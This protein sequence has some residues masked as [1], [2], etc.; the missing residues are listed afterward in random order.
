MHFDVYRAIVIPLEKKLY[1]TKCSDFRTIILLGHA[2]KVLI[3]I[4]TKRI[5]AKAEG[6]GYIA[7]DQFGFRRGKG[8]RDAIAALRVISE[9]S[10]QHGK[11]LHVCFVDYE[12]AF[13]RLNWNKMMWMLKNIGIDWRDRNLIAVVF[14]TKG[15]Y[16]NKR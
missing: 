2:A 15:C 11:D 3:R 16:K 9:R 7:D 6:I 4:L 10:L 12:K 14:G 1:A 8:T 13:D 5:E